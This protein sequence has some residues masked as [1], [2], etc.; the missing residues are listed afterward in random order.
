MPENDDDIDNEDL[1]CSWEEL[2]VKQHR[3]DLGEVSKENLEAGDTLAMLDR[4]CI[5][6]EFTR[7]VFV[8]IANDE[9]VLVFDEH[10]E[11]IDEPGNFVEGGWQKLHG[12]HSF[13]EEWTG[14][15]D[16]GYY[17]L[18]VP[19]P[20]ETEE[21]PAPALESATAP[22]PADAAVARATVASVM[23]REHKARIKECFGT[24]V[25]DEEGKWF[26]G[27]VVGISE[28][29]C[30]IGWDDGDLQPH[31]REQIQGLVEMGKLSVLE[32]PRGLVADVWQADKVCGASHLRVKEELYPVGALL[33]DG[34]ATLC[35]KPIYSSHVLSLTLLETIP[36]DAK[37]P[38]RGAGGT[39]DNK[40]GGMATF[41]RGDTVIST[42]PTGAQEAVY[43]VMIF[44]HRKQQ[45][46]YVITYDE[47]L[48]QFSMGSWTAWRRVPAEGQ[49]SGEFEPDAEGA[50]VQTAAA[51]AVSDMYTKWQASPLT[52]SSLD[53]LH[54]R[55]A[56][57]NSRCGRNGD[58]HSAAGCTFFLTSL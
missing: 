30:L 38:S 42:G 28:A 22:A 54:S 24:S 6:E 10:G 12:D 13:T 7:R 55:W 56:H 37:R 27:L 48:E 53:T 9:N 21:A 31:S 49:E 20:G 14:D 40:R 2:V 33:G 3:G 25:G 51:E 34:L 4:N 23:S 43:G 46:R 39:G 16:D 47:Q 8:L 5:T 19:L 52:F 17:N 50:Q 44:N 29:G 41:R 32:D 11:P 35:G 57:S 58:S 18:G 36:S 15:K 26:G 45:H 1:G